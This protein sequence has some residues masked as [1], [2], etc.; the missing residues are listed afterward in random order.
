MLVALVIAAVPLSAR[1]AHHDSPT[2]GTLEAVSASPTP[3]PVY[4]RGFAGAP[5]NRPALRFDGYGCVVYALAHAPNLLAQ[6][7]TVENLDASFAKLRAAEYPTA[8]GQLQNQLSKQANSVGTFGQFGVTPQSNFSENTAQLGSTYNLYNG[9]AQLSAEQAKKQVDDAKEELL[10]LQEQTAISVTNAFYQL[11][12]DRGTTELDQSDL[13]YQ[14][15][16]LDEAQAEERV[17][18]VAGVDVLRAEVAVARSR[19]ALVQARAVEANDRENLAVQIGASYDTAFDVPDVLPEPPLPVTPLDELATIAKMNRPEIAEA[20]SSLDVSKL[21]DA[22]VD[23]DL[24]PVIQLAGSFGSQVSPTLLVSEQQQID[25]ANQSALSSFAAE[26]VLFPNVF[27]P[28][29]TLIP[30]LSRHVPGF[31]QFSVLSTFTVPLY[32]YGQ[33]AALHHAARAQINSSLASLY[34]AY[35]SV[36]ADV[37]ASERNL[38]AAAEKLQLAKLADQQARESARIAELQY[39]GGVISFTDATQTEQT[40]LAAENDLVTARVAYVTTLIKLREALGPP[41]AAAAADLR[42]L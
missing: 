4:G 37:D 39:K 12:A 14:Q 36:Q 28:P 6:L 23:N 26:K 10:R 34:N 1:A 20:R 38:Q 5:G 30:P 3:A 19:S 15:T 40:A 22:S 29:P 24:R 7:A 18:R 2:G 8:T 35:D 9:G 41:N 13:R 27:I 11:A 17:G 25:A 42:S 21:T 31:W 32:D 16:L 33:R